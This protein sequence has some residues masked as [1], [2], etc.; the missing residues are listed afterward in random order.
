MQAWMI[1]TIAPWYIMC[2]DDFMKGFELPPFHPGAHI[3]NAYNL[4]LK[5][6][7]KNMSF[8]INNECHLK[9]TWKHYSNIT[10]QYWFIVLVQHCNNKQCQCHIYLGSN[11]TQ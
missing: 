6:Y 8:E 5:E 1:C 9:N 2:G 10:L 4:I 11:N 7:G 3:G